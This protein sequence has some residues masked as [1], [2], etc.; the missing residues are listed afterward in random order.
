MP[1][2]EKKRFQINDSVATLRKCK[3][4]SKF[5]PKQ[6]EEGE[7]DQSSETGDNKAIEKKI[8]KTKSEFFWNSNKI[9]NLL[10]NLQ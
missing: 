1:L 9:K 2:L 6:A 8:N 3:K 5:N 7:K 10:G 4:K